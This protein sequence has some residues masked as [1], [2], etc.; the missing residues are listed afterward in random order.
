MTDTQDSYII[1]FDAWILPNQ[2]LYEVAKIIGQI[3]SIPLSEC[4]TSQFDEYPAYALELED[5]V[6]IRLMGVPPDIDNL[7]ITWPSEFDE[8]DKKYAICISCHSPLP[9]TLRNGFA[10]PYRGPDDFLVGTMQRLRSAGL[11]ICDSP[12]P[13]VQVGTQVFLAS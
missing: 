2:P 8:K 6:F 9:C 10:L 4:S 3:Y 11:T 7:L 1:S 12:S 5:T 13:F